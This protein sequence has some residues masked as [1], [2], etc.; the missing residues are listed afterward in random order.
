[1]IFAYQAKDVL[2]QNGQTQALLDLLDKCHGPLK[3][4]PDLYHAAMSWSMEHKQKDMAEAI[5]MH[6]AEKFPDN[7]V[8]LDTF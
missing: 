5:L 6:A 1:M 4:G 2:I 3:A 7:L 8:S